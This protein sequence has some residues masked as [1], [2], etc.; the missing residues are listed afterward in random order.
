MTAT[1]NNSSAL[2]TATVESDAKVVKK[3]LEGGADANATTVSGVTALHA[4]MFVLGM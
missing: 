1:E 4:A 3:E 2:L